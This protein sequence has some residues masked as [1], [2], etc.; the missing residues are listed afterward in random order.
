ML[1]LAMSDNSD[2]NPSR[3]NRIAGVAALLAGCSWVSWAI[4]NSITG[5]AFDSA[6][7]TVPLRLAKLGQLLTIAWNLLLIPAAL[8]LWIRVRK[9]EPELTL[10]FTVCGTLSLSIW[11]VGS[12]ASVNSPML[13]VCYLLLSSVWW[14]GI[15]DAL[16]KRNGVFGVFTIIVGV[17][18]LLDAILSFFEPMPFYIYVLAAPKL[19]L[20]ILWDFWL[21]Y[22]L[23]TDFGDS[24]TKASLAQA[25]VATYD[26]TKSQ[27]PTHRER[28][29]LQAAKS[30]SRIQEKVT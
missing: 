18:A 29:E 27:Q 5:G 12:A 3:M 17:F 26:V 30:T 11:A 8:A 1:Q 23:L 13:E 25:E 10:L 14:L 19:P 28:A 6:A 20:A 2:S 24:V 16:R 7:G 4:V 15:G 22:M 21:G 9:Q